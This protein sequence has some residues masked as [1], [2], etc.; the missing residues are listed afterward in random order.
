MRILY[1]TTLSVIAILDLASAWECSLKCGRHG[2]EKCMGEKNKTKEETN[3]TEDGRQLLEPHHYDDESGSFLP[4]TKHVETKQVNF[5][6]S[7]HVASNLRGSSS[8]HDDTSHRRLSGFDFQVK[9][10]WKEGFC[11]SLSSCM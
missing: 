10:Y 7:K 8:N 3:A 11:V 9:M 5:Q 2:Y 1:I 4:E 6:P